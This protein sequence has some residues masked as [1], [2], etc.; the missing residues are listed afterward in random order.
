M[1]RGFYLFMG[2][3]SWPFV[4]GLFRLQTTGLQTL[5]RQGG[6]VLGVNHLSNVDPWA[7]GL[8]LWPGRRLRWMGKVEL[9]N[10]VLSPILAAV[11]A[12]PVRRGEGDLGAIQTAIDVCQSGDVLVM[13]PEG[14]RRKKGLRKRFEV[15]AHTGA[16]RIALAARVPLVPAAVAGTDRLARL[17]RIRVAYGRPIPLD[18]LAGM[19]HR[20]AAGIATDR[21]MAEIGRL[22]AALVMR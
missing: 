21:L 6:F 10:P 17:D 2:I 4:R 16:A 7:V 18:D 1:S 19:T 9:F 8:P 15:R 20:D 12:F 5:P 22:E 13:F 11:G 14:T 3:V